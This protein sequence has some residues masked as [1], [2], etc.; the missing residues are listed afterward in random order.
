[1]WSQ[2]LYLEFVLVQILQVKYNPQ[3]LQQMLLANTISNDDV[4]SINFGQLDKVEKTKRIEAVVKLL[5]K[6][7]VSREAYQSIA[8]IE[9]NI[10]REGD[11]YNI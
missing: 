8:K 9:P 5:D 11:V 4:Y 7:H 2:N 1:M 6:G 10:S 3:N